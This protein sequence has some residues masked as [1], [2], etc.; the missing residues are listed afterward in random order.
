MERDGD[1][2]RWTRTLR[3]GQTGGVVLEWMGGEPRRVTPEEAQRLA[4][5]TARFWRSWLAR[6]TYQGR[7]R[8]M[9]TRSA[10][11]LKLMTYAPT[12]ALVAAPTTGLPEQEGGE[13]NWDYRYT[14][15]RDGSFSIY[16]LL[17][18]GYIEEAA[19]FGIWLRDRAA[20]YTGE[21][22]PLKIMY[23]V[24]GS[25]DLVEETLDHFE[26]W[27]GSRPVRIGNGAADQLQLDIYGEAADAFYLA[28]SQGLQAAHEGWTAIARIIDWLC[29]HWDQPDEGIWE[30]RGGQRG[31]HLRPV[32]GLG[33]PRP[34]HQ[35]RAAPGPPG[36]RGPVDRSS[37]TASTTRSSTAAGT[38]RSARSPSTT[39]P[40]CWTPRC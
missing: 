21:G 32:P 29:D 35:D 17:S 38:P 19:A 33:R 39:P 15:I 22:R 40:K 9:V 28:D 3:E 27:R 6:S 5:D 36:Q 1:G 26:G 30:T 13:R 8:E 7:W 23:R 12:G 14:W 16:A 4:D 10:M 20:E 2:V 34:R 18:L 25:S 37:G 24:D 31:L 11:T